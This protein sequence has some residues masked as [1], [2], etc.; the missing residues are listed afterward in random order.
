M[1]GSSHVALKYPPFEA[2]KPDGMFDITIAD[3]DFLDFPCFFSA[4]SAR[5][6]RFFTSKLDMKFK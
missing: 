5:K 6:I 1:Y 4:T 2:G 3:V